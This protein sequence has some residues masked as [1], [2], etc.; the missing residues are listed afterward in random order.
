VLS[1]EVARAHWVDLR[2]LAESAA[3][4]EVFHH[5]ALRTM[6]CYRIGENVVWGMTHRILE[7]L[8]ELALRDARP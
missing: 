5:G 7:P 8:V 4:T 1:N 3:T 2:Q 6:P